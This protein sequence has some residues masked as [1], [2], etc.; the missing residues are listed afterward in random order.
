MKKFLL[1]LTAVVLLLLMFVSCSKPEQPLTA[2]ELL[3]L[4]EKYL[5]ELNYEQALVQFLKVIEIEPMN[6]RGYTGAAESYVGLGR[7]SEAVEILELGLVRTGDD[8][9]SRML[10]NL[11]HISEQESEYADT[12]NANNDESEQSGYSLGD[13]ITVQATLDVRTPENDNWMAY[14]KELEEQ[15]GSGVA[16]MTHGIMFAEPITL[17]DGTI[18][19]EAT[20]T[21]QSAAPRFFDEAIIQLDGDGWL[22]NTAMSGNSYTFTGRLVARDNPDT[23]IPFENEYGVWVT[24]YPWGAFIF[25]LTTEV[26]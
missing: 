13:E 26:E 23:P 19:G 3:N 22:P 2:A 1:V 24:Y 6:P 12:I 21:G 8:G 7:M 15:H 10:D 17:P 11:S 16:F 14:I 4:G 18:I 9:I 25:E 5:L 20:L